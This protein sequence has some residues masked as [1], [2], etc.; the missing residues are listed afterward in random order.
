MEQTEANRVVNTFNI[1]PYLSAGVN[2][3]RL[4]ITKN[5]GGDNDSASS[6][7]WTINMVQFYL[8]WNYDES[9]I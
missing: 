8:T 2:S 5:T 7:S 4:R 6:T 3:V 9:T 1:A